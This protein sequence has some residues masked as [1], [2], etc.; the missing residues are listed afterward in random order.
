LIEDDPEQSLLKSA[1]WSY[2]NTGTALALQ[3][4]VTGYV[5]RRFSIGD[6]GFFAITQTTLSLVQSVESTG[7]LQVT[8]I[9]TRSASGAARL[10]M[11][12]TLAEISF[13]YFR[14]ACL[15]FLVTCAAAAVLAPVESVQ[16]VMLVMAMALIYFLTIASSTARG[17]LLGTRRYDWLFL[18]TAANAVAVTAILALLPARLG[19]GRIGLA[20]LVGVVASRLVMLGVLSRVPAFAALRRVR[21]TAGPGRT[22]R[23]A[24]SIGG[25][26]ATAQITALVDVALIAG[27]VGTGA[28]GIYRIAMLAPTQAIGVFYQGVDVVLPRLAHMEGTEERAQLIKRITLYATAVGAGGLASLSLM[29]P[30]VIQ[31]LAGR[32]LQEAQIVVSL[33]CLTWALNIPAHIL[34]IASL[35]AHQQERVARVSVAE[36]AIK[37]ALSAWLLAWLGIPGAA[38]AS[39]LTVGV[40]NLVAVPVVLR[41]ADWMPPLVTLLSRAFIGLACGILLATLVHAP[42]SSLRL[43]ALPHVATEG[44]LTVGML[45]CACLLVERRVAARAREEVRDA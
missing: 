1:V 29:A 27:I 31:V 30:Q 14:A 7:S 13:V 3:L 16:R 12:T 40:S 10:R 36:A 38:L 26:S 15:A 44:I 19:L 33:F 9:A 28:S 32:Q 18:A 4:A 43:A 42:I 34:A 45:S 5:A 22:L 2:A 23:E 21:R 41:R 17:C 24:A 39:L 11:R 6:F 8:R 20:L 37:I 25:L 35:A